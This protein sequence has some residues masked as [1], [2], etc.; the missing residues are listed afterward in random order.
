MMQRGARKYCFVLEHHRGLI[1]FTEMIK[2]LSI[3]DTD[4]DNNDD[5]LDVHMY[6]I[7]GRGSAERISVMF[8]RKRQPNSK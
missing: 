7:A 1:I 6:P 4:D 2:L 8:Q 5:N 3:S